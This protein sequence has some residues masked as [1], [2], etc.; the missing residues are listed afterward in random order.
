[1]TPWTVLTQVVV[2]GTTTITASGL[3]PANPASSAV[4]IPASLLEHRRGMY[5]ATDAD[6]LELIV[7]EH[8]VRLNPTTL[9]VA[10]AALYA[11]WGPDLA[12]LKP[13]V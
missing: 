11:V 7:W 6:T 5:L 8:Y 4:Q 10:P 3:D 9:E 13:S 1:M 12:P 2:D